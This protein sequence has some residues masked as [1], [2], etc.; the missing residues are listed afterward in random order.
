MHEGARNLSVVAACLCCFFLPW[1]LQAGDEWTV[2]QMDG[3]TI[4]RQGE[5]EERRNL[6]IE[7]NVRVGAFGIFLARFEVLL[8]IYGTLPSQLER[9]ERGEGRGVKALL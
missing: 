1:L 6:K 5:G 4:E 8:L 2:A 3:Q 9:E 7:F